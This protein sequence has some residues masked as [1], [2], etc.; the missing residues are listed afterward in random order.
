[1]SYLKDNLEVGEFLVTLEFAK[2]YSFKV[3]DAVQSYHWTNDQATLHRYV[4]CY[5]NG[6]TTLNKCFVVISDENK[7]DLVAVHLF[8]KK[9]I[10]Y[11]SVTFG[12]ENIK[13]IIFSKVEHK[14]QTAALQKRFKTAQ[15]IQ[16]TRSYHSFKPIDANS[17]ACK[18]FSSSP[19]FVVH[20]LQ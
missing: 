18:E 10:N 19:D 3:Q 7:H 14:K 13:K 2:N 4:V 12:S 16:G 5:K 6:R 17:M 15:I 20:K 1:M 11:L 9:M 8:N